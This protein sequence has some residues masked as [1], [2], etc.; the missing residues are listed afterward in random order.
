MSSETP[1]REHAATPSPPILIRYNKKR[2][3]YE[4]YQ[5]N[6]MRNSTGRFRGWWI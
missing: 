4:E 5:L 2:K 1:A 3:E 6:K